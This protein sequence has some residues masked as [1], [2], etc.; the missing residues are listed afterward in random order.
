LEPAWEKGDEE[1]HGKLGGQ[2][3][4]CSEIQTSHIAPPKY[5]SEML[6]TELTC[7]LLGDIHRRLRNAQNSSQ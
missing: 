1:N 4:W 2:V 3:S 6:Q 5:K 7:Y